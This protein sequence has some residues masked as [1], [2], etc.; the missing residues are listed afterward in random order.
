[1]N[2]IAIFFVGKNKFGLHLSTISTQLF[3]E[4]KPETIV[5]NQTICY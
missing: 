2:F 1:V 3:K 4:F 5:N